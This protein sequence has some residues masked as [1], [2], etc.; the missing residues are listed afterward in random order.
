VQSHIDLCAHCATELDDLRAFRATLSTFP[1]KTYA[2]AEQPT[3]PSF[4]QRLTSGKRQSGRVPGWQLAGA[5]L[6]AA[7]IGYVGA[8]AP[9]RQ[10]INTQQQQITALNSQPHNTTP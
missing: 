9:L 3:K 1:A 8:A 10:Q 2:P 7:F 4:W 6:A 5:S